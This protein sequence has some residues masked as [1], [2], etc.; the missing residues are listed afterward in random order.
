MPKCSLL[1]IY[2]INSMSVFRTDHLALAASLCAFPWRRPL[3]HSELL[4]VACGSLCRVG[5][6]RAF[7]CSVWHVHLCHPCSARIWVIMMVR[8]CG[9]SF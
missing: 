6:L 2:N 3:S 5:A 7:T 9:S 8:L 1:S 4:S